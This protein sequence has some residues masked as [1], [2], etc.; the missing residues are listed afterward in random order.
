MAFVHLANRPIESNPKAC[1]AA[2]LAAE[3]R[4]HVGQR[5]VG[6]VGYHLEGSYSELEDGETGGNPFGFGQIPQDLRDSFTS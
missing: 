4:A 3:K 6:Y 1:R 5:G 2:T